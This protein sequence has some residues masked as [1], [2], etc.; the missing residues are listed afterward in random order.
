[1]QSASQQQLELAIASARW[2]LLFFIIVTRLGLFL[3]QKNGRWTYLPTAIAVV[4]AVPG[5]SNRVFVH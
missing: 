2:L 1:M 4:E 5:S 3:W